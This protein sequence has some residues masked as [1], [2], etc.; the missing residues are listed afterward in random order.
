[1][2]EQR[3]IIAFYVYVGGMSQIKAQRYLSDLYESLNID[4]DDNEKYIIVPI[5]SGESRVDVLNPIRLSDT[6]YKEIESRTDK[7][8]SLLNTFL[9]ASHLPIDSDESSDS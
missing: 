9:S 2:S 6:D 1:M 8:E 3:L 5:N 4:K 7:L